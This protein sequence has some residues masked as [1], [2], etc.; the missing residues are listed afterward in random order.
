MQHELSIPVK[1][2]ANSAAERIELMERKKKVDQKVFGMNQST[3]G[4]LDNGTFGSQ[5]QLLICVHNLAEKS[6]NSCWQ[7]FLCC[8]GDGCHTIVDFWHF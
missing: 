6:P 3:K 2:N 4:E 7:H 5:V 8:L 1:L